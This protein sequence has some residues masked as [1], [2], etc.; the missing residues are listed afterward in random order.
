[1]SCGLYW[2]HEKNK[3]LFTWPQLP[4]TKKKACHGWKSQS[5]DSTMLL[6]EEPWNHS[7]TC[8]YYSLSH[9]VTCWQSSLDLLYPYA[10]CCIFLRNKYTVVLYVTVLAR[11]CVCFYAVLSVCVFAVVLSGHL[12]LELLIPVLYPCCALIWW[13]TGS[14]ISL[15]AYSAC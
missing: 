13:Y 5:S 11:V 6:M 14:V 7:S 8:K 9:I 12:L 2:R 3:N 15:H 10:G 4:E 1:M